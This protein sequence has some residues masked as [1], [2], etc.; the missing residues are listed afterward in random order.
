MKK[1]IAFLSVM[2]FS[3]VLAVQTRTIPKL[4]ATQ[5]LRIPRVNVCSSLPTPQ[6]EG[7][8]CWDKDGDAL[9]V[10]DGTSFLAVSTPSGSFAVTAGETF[11][12]TITFTG[13]M[14]STTAG[15]GINF[16]PTG[17]DTDVHLYSVD[18]LSTNTQVFWRDTTK[19]IEFAIE[20]G[21]FENGL[22]T[23]IREDGIEIEDTIIAHGSTGSSNGFETTITF[24]D[25]TAD[26]AVTFPDLAGEVGVIVNGTTL[27]FEGSTPDGNETTLSMVDSTNNDNIITFPDTT[28]TVLVTG[29]GDLQCTGFL[30]SAVYNPDETADEFVSFN[31]ANPAAGPTET[32]EDD[33]IVPAVLNFHTLRVAVDVD[34]TGSGTWVIQLRDDRVDVTTIT[35]S[36][37]SGSTTCAS[38]ET[39]AVAIAAGSK[40]NMDVSRTGGNPAAAAEM[41]IS[42]CYNP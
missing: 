16:G 15:S 2:V 12:G 7:D 14:A 39:V 35:C 8:M 21:T 32:L 40:I 9:Y 18:R 25:P 5:K 38:A 33:F 27:T 4:N 24:T 22:N 3:T 30:A 26:R 23:A 10:H 34:P 1:L 11:T 36:I 28:G 42:V 17:S 19:V 41:L 20:S 37:A 13:L 6:Q 29:T 31:V